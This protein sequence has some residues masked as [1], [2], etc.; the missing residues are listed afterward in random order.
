MNRHTSSEFFKF[1]LLGLPGYV[2]AVLLNISLTA[3]SGLSLPSIYAVVLL[4]Q[5]STNYIFLSL[6]L[7]PSDR[8]ETVASLLSNYFSFLLSISLFRSLEWIMYS[9]LVLNFPQSFIF[10][11]TICI[12]GFSLSKYLVSK[13]ILRP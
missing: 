9:I 12:A 1:L 10:I 7:F 8:I 11:Q 5:V 13:K 3:N 2:I 6:F 4:I